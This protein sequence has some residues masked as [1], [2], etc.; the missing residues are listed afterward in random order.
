MISRATAFEICMAY[1]EIAKGK[2]LLAKIKS[3][4]DDGEAPMIADAFGRHQ[5]MQ[6]GIPSGEGR[7]RLLD[8][9]PELA[10]TVI[11]AHIA[12]KRAVLAALNEKAKSE[13]G[14]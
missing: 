7:H 9:A 4:K 12:N 11:G 3:L 13:C 2:D 6:L 14:V 10:Q 5:N 1:D 8:V